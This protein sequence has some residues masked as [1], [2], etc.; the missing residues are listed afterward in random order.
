MFKTSLQT[1]LRSF[2]KRKGYSILNLLGLTIGI[3]CC[4]LIFEYV[5]YE[6]SYDSF[7]ANANRIYRVQESDY[8]GGRLEASWATTSPAVGPTLKKDFPEIEN[9]CRLIQWNVQL[10]NPANNALFSEQKS[11]MADNSTLSVL[12]MPL[13]KGNP[14]TALTVVNTIVLSEKTAQKYFGNE[15]PIGKT[16]YN[17]VG[18]EPPIKVTGIF[19]DLPA[20]SHL[21]IDMLISY[22]PC[23]T[24]SAPTKT[25]KTLPRQSGPGTI[26]IPISSSNPARTGMLSRPN[27][28]TSSTGTTTPARKQSQQ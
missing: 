24:I 28:P 17:E 4:L 9:F 20:N 18:G 23:D 11:Y 22:P 14:A 13:L 3:T 16:L 27:C 2:T 8:Q 25:R 1:A 7:N 21:V 6:R 10:V 5:A 15:D 26:T 12:Q 19:K